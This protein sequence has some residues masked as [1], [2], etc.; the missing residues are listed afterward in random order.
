MLF[1]VSKKVRE[2]VL[3]LLLSLYKIF[4]SL[5]GCDIFLKTV[6]YKSGLPRIVHNNSDGYIIICLNKISPNDF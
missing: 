5:S 4:T 3:N 2:G 6:S 1:G